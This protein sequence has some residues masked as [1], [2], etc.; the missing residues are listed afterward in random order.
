MAPLNMS[1]DVQQLELTY[2]TDGNVRNSTITLE[3][4]QLSKVAVGIKVFTLFPQ[5]D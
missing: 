5:N 1:E 2:S 4:W 3:K